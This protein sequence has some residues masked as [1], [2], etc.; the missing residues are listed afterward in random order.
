MLSFETTDIRIRHEEGRFVASGNVASY[1]GMSLVNPVWFATLGGGDQWIEWQNSCGNASRP[2]MKR[3]ER[4]RLW[5][6]TMMPVSIMRIPTDKGQQDY[7]CMSFPNDAALANIFTT[8]LVHGS[9]LS[10]SVY[11]LSRIFEQ[12]DEAAATWD[13]DFKAGRDAI[14]S[15]HPPTVFLMPKPNVEAPRPEPA[16]VK[17]GFFG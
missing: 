16:P 13:E 17:R 5:S 1:E 11:H 12:N 7:I 15:R 6:D 3:A 4:K 9:P 10:F 14:F 2:V 8:A